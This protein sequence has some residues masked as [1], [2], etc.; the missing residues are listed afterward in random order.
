MAGGAGQRWP[1]STTAAV[2]E[3]R[4]VQFGHGLFASR[5][6]VH[7]DNA[8]AVWE[9]SGY[10]AIA[11]DWLGLYEDDLPYITEMF[12]RGINDFEQLPARLLQAQ[13]NAHAAMA[14]LIAGL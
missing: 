3:C 9:R 1:N 2:K 5:R 12:I 6:E 13:V 7:S 8:Q 10:F 11:T 4:V 14:N